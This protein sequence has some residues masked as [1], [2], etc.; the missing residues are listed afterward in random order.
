MERALK[1]LARR[2]GPL[3]TVVRY[4]TS[5]EG[6]PLLAMEAT[7][8]STGSAGEKPGVALIA[9]IQ[10]DE[11]GASE[12]ALRVLQRLLESHGTDPAGTDLLRT[13][14]IWVVPRAN[15]DGIERLFGK[16]P[17]LHRHLLAP[18]DDDSDEEIDE[19]GPQDVDGDGLV[20]QMRLRDPQGPWRADASD[21]RLL[22]RAKPGEQGEFRLLP[23]GRDQDGDGMVAEDG[24]GGTDLNRNFPALWQWRTTQPGA[25]PFMASAEETRALMDFLLARPSIGLV[26]V[27][28]GSGR[29]PFYPA[30]RLGASLASDDKAL[31]ERMGR[32]WEQATGRKIATPATTPGDPGA[33]SLLDWVCLHFGALAHSP[34]IWSPP[35]APAK[36]GADASPPAQP[37][38]REDGRVASASQRAPRGAA[39]QAPS[40]GQANGSE[41]AGAAGEERAWLAW[42]DRE[43]GGT[44]FVA[45]KPFRHPDLGEVE[46]GGWKPFTRDNPPAG[47][48]EEMA[49]KEHR[50]FVQFALQSP[51]VRIH[52][53]VAEPAAP[54]AW[55]VR[56]TAVNEGATPTACSQGVL[57]RTTRP[58]L[59]ILAL[60]EGAKI[61]AGVPRVKMG[62]MGPQERK[63]VEWIVAAPAGARL[64]I[65]LDAQRGGVET[66][67]VVPH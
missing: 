59:G 11:A 22:V 8:R 21:P 26:C 17:Q 58:V 43:L 50:F 18:L 28:H 49:E 36:S 66:R 9:G 52:E 24:P 47:K 30:G 44:G 27:L 6:R 61:L 45:W 14:A 56:L 34:E 15:P 23:E 60:S 38:N 10:G 64:R 31:L 62:Q 33:G 13:R 25:G 57:S 37:L 7:D 2:H 1:D 55:R 65:T 12:V 53:A 4:G 35:A 3:A 19:D 20:L 67:E 46:I 39:G 32:L 40:G 63:T 54:G 48:L 41:D 16:A 51:R 42:N 29:Q 5:H